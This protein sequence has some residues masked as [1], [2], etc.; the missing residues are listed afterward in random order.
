MKVMQKF[1]VLRDEV[2]E[3]VLLKRDL[4]KIKKSPINK[5]I[6]GIIEK[7]NEINKARHKTNII[8]IYISK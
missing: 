2:F 5:E 3:R 7:H 8:F 6:N 1:N 4:L